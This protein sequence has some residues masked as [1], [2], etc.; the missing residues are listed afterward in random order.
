[1]SYPPGQQPPTWGPGQQPPTWSQQPP[2]AWGTPPQQ[3][4]VN[5]GKAG[6]NPALIVGVFVGI[7]VLRARHCR[8]LHRLQPATRTRPA[9]PAGRAVRARRSV[10]AAHRAGIADTRNPGATNP[11]RAPNA[12]SDRPAREWSA[13]C[14]SRF[15]EAWRDP[16]QR[17]ATVVSGRLELAQL[18]AELRVRVRPRDLRSLTNQTDELAVLDV[19]SLDAQIVVVAS[20]EGITPNELIA[21]QLGVVDGFLIGRVG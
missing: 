16:I 21:R 1:M 12:G 13:D 20:D 6:T 10:T 2:Q 18:N 9:V 11:D 19:R 7:L 3:Y 8:R 4:S 5:P 14:S 17:L 15:P